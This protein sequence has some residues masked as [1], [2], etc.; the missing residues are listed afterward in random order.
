[1]AEQVQKEMTIYHFD[2]EAELVSWV[3]DALFMRFEEE[4]PEW[5]DGEPTE[6][7]LETHLKVEFVLRSP[8]GSVRVRYLLYSDAAAFETEVQLGPEDLVVLDLM[9]PGPDGNLE[10][11][12]LTLLD[13]AIQKGVQRDRI[14]L[15]TAYPHTLEKTLNDRVDRKQILVKPPDAEGLIRELVGKMKI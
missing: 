10:E 1:M 9:G 2:D 6:E 14:Y 4:H 13:H 8:G 15:L 11:K 7:P 12:G 3:P 5:I